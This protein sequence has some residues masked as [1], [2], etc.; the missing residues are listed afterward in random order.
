MYQSL[1]P[2]GLCCRDGKMNEEGLMLSIAGE[3]SQGTAGGK[4]VYNFQNFQG[5]GD[6]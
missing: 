6:K 5:G 1:S 3:L 2:T 4:S